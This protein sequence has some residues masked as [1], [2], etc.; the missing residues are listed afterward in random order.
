MLA[1]LSG[2]TTGNPFTPVRGRMFAGG[3][4]FSEL[5]ATAP[6]GD[7]RGLALGV[8]FILS[9]P[10]LGPRARI[11]QQPAPSVCKGRLPTSARGWL[12]TGYFPS[13]LGSTDKRGR[14][15]AVSHTVATRRATATSLPR[16]VLQRYSESKARCPRELVI[17]AHGNEPS[18]TADPKPRRGAFRPATRTAVSIRRSAQQ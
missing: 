9:C 18:H 1:G 6:R 3:D 13:S 15:V 10:G 4:P 8:C 14:W 7:I 5:P 17:P 11:P 12:S 16:G 2:Q